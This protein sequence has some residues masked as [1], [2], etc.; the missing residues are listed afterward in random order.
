MPGRSPAAEWIERA[1]D[2]MEGTVPE[3][4]PAAWIRRHAAWNAVAGCAQVWGAKDLVRRAAIG[5][6]RAG[7]DVLKAWMRD[8]PFPT[9]AGSRRLHLADVV[10]LDLHRRFGWDS[11]FGREAVAGA[12]DAAWNRCFLPD[13]NAAGGGGARLVPERAEVAAIEPDGSGSG[14]HAAEDGEAWDFAGALVAAGRIQAGATLARCLA[15]RTVGADD[16]AVWEFVD[17]WNGF[18][19]DAP[20]AALQWAPVDRSGYV[21]APLRTDTAIGLATGRG[22]ETGVR[23]TVA[24]EYGMLRLRRLTLPRPAGY[25]PGS[26]LAT[27]GRERVDARWTIEGGSIRVEWDRPVEVVPGRMMYVSLLSIR[28]QARRRAPMPKSSGTRVAGTGGVIK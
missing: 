7:Q 25:T 21:R 2:G 8:T 15:R 19:I 1:V 16:P 22:D 24:L 18:R 23:A 27:C 9:R 13:G 20:G 5:R 28:A 26:A 4:V 6:E 3:P 11:P 14:G 12:L 17:G 10:A